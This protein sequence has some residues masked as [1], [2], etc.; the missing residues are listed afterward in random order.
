LATYFNKITTD[1][2][3]AIESPIVQGIFRV[4]LLNSS[5]ESFY[6]TITNSAVNNNGTLTT[7]WNNGLRRTFTLDLVN[8]DN[9]YLFNPNSNTGL[10]LDSKMKV[11]NGIQVNDDQYY[12]S[13]GVFLLNAPA[14]ISQFSD[15]RIT[16]NGSDK[17]CLL[18]GS[19]GAGY[20]SQDTE[21]PLG[22]IFYE[23]IKLILQLSNDPISPV[24]SET[25]FNQVIPCN[26]I[27]NAGGKI[28]DLLDQVCQCFSCNYGYSTDGILTIS[29]G[30]QDL[31]D[32]LKPSEF[33]FSTI[34]NVYGGTNSSG[35]VFNTS[36]IYNIVSVIGNNVNGQTTS[37]AIVASHIITYN[38]SNIVGYF[39]PTNGEL[40]SNF[41][42]GGTNV[43]DLG[44][45]TSIALL[46]SNSTAQITISGTIG[47]I[48]Q[49]YTI[50]PL[51]AAL[52]TG[53]TA[54]TAI[55]IN[56]F[57]NPEDA[58]TIT[59]NG[60][61][62]SAIAT[63]DDLTS[64]LCVQRIG[65]RVA[66]LVQ[67]QNISTNALAQQRAAYE[68]KKYTIAQ[69][70]FNFT[71]SFVP[72]LQ[73]NQVVTISDPFLDYSQQRVLLTQIQFDLNTAGNVTYQGSNTN[74][75]DFSIT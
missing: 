64:P 74:E 44:H 53:Y 33:D 15:R 54:P 22:T 47:A 51:Q 73:E 66:P 29:D 12:F 62:A 60:I 36:Q 35:N 39:D 14:V 56:V 2:L 11:Y 48:T 38:L 34:S 3:N 67:D 32:S 1:Y 13:Q 4:D 17:Y 16:I 27:V 72:H 21:I 5:D 40:I 46:N 37:T 8:E 45:I 69:T 7:N 52:G 70:T 30:S 65:E 23:A 9:S 6:K 26:I 58:T 25:Y 61:T 49:N 57:E 59:T 55:Q 19:N 63:N 10:W 20:L 28:S 75:L 43:S 18:D 41:I 24:I 31:D 50:A 71:S 68:L 42:L